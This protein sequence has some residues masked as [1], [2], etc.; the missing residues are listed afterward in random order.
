MK[1]PTVEQI[2]EE[3]L[4]D[5]VYSESDTSWR[6]GEYRTEVYYREEDKTYWEVRYQISTDGEYNTL[7]DDPEM[8]V[9]AQVEPYEKTVIAY[10][11]V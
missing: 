6:H 1:K 9:F 7:R 10:K 3:E 4:G 2:R 5:P 8:V 11:L